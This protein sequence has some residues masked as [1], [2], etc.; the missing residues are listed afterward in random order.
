MSGFVP[1]TTSSTRLAEIVRDVAAGRRYVAP[2]NAASALT[3]ND[4]PL[5]ARELEVLN[6]SR[7]GA[8]INQIAAEVRLAPGTVRNYLSSAMAKLGA[9]SRHAAAHR[10]WEEGWIQPWPD[11]IRTGNR[12]PQLPTPGRRRRCSARLPRRWSW[13]C[14]A[15]GTRPVSYDGLRR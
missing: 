15:F 8:S 7:T 10:A 1:K 12:F 2:D 14:W 11:L 3:E 4:C 13:N 6:P 5:T 9:N